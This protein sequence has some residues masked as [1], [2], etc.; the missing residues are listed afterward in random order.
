MQMDLG[1]AHALSPERPLF[2]RLARARYCNAW[3]KVTQYSRN[4]LMTEQVDGAHATHV[5]CRRVITA[6]LCPALCQGYSPGT[7]DP[8]I[9]RNGAAGAVPAYKG[10]A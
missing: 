7:I 5:Y 9:S 6:L 10:L 1:L 3:T 8:P 2:A 4:I